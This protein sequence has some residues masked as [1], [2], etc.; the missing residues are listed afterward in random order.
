[1]SRQGGFINNTIICNAKKEVD[2]DSLNMLAAGEA[3]ELCVCSYKSE[4]NHHHFI[5]NIADMFP[6]SALQAGQTFENVITIL[7]DAVKLIAFLSQNG[8]ALDNVKLAK[9]YIFRAEFRYKFIYIP[10]KSK[11][12]LKVRDFVL[13]LLS[14]VHHKDIRLNAFIKE[15]RK[16]KEDNKAFECLSNFVA[17]YETAHIDYEAATS[18]LTEEAETTVLS[19]ESET[20]LLSAEPVVTA[21]DGTGYEIEGDG[22]REEGETSL[23]S[24]EAETSLL[25]SEPIIYENSDTEGETTVLSQQIYENESAKL[26]EFISDNSAEYETTVLTSQ[27]IVQRQINISDMGGNYS[28]HLMRTLNG[29]DVPVYV[30]P[31]TIGKDSSN[32]DY[33][34]NGYGVSRQHATIMYEDGCYYILDNNSTNGTM[35]EG[36]K[37]QPGEK[38]EIGNGCIISL[39]NETF[40]VRIEQH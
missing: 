26:T 9:E 22:Y 40:Q 28:L 6:L 8:M 13:K 15:I 24:G 29:E 36:V 34:L 7:S 30:T 12:H 20:T 19:S 11:P 21:D 23:L 17:S 5:Y 31:F 4:K 38:A 27:P 35:I 37:I 10:I 16:C 2:L 25:S 1:M 39:G 33:V 3:H 18:L 32:V 14:V